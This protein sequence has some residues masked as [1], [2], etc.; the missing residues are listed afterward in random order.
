MLK[1]MLRKFLEPP[2]SLG[3]ILER[4]FSQATKTE[5]LSVKYPGT[6][7]LTKKY[8]NI[9]LSRKIPRTRN[10]AAKISWFKNSHLDQI[11]KL[12]LKK[13]PLKTLS[14]KSQNK[15][16]LL[17]LLFTTSLIPKT[18]V[19]FQSQKFYEKKFYRIYFYSPEVWSPRH[20]P[21]YASW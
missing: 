16:E 15:K 17:K 14:K 12:P 7:I 21:K 5:I 6:E 3:K 1:F 4:K 11:L 20:V 9:F 19:N 8:Q 13:L 18:Q 2:G 10:C